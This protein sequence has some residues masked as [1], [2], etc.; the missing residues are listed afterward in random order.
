MC[1]NLCGIPEDLSLSD[2][3]EEH[4]IQ[5]INHSPDW[6]LQYTDSGKYLPSL[7]KTNGADFRMPAVLSGKCPRRKKIAL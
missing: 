4:L 7:F 2:L 5:V 3:L 6:G 1:G